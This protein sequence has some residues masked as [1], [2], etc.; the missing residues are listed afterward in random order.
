MLISQCCFALIHWSGF[1]VVPVLFPGCVNREKSAELQ[2]NSGGDVNIGN[3]QVGKNKTEFH[4]ILQKTPESNSFQMSHFRQGGS[5]VEGP[6]FILTLMVLNA[7][8]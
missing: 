4:P 3:I 5:G 7:W 2:E 8:L 6:L 1:T